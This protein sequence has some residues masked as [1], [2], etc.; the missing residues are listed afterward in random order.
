M[1]CLIFFHSFESLPSLRLKCDSFL[2]PVV[3]T[4]CCCHLFICCNPKLGAEGMRPL[5]HKVRDPV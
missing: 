3:E 2:T 4:C 1:V 5:Q